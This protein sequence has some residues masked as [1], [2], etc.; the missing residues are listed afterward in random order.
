MNSSSE[1]AFAALLLLVLGLL[2]QLRPW[3]A[4]VGL[5]KAVPSQPS[6]TSYG[7]CT[8]HSGSSHCVQQPLPSNKLVLYC[9]PRN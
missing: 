8:L 2:S 7:V 5:K 4:V 1:V 3:T 9:T 6:F